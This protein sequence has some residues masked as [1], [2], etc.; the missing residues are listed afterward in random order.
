MAV[1]AGYQDSFFVCFLT[2]LPI[3]LC[4]YLQIC[5]RKCPLSCKK[6]IQLIE[7]NLSQAHFQ[8]KKTKGNR[9]GNHPH[10]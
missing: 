9:N 1:Q 4:Y 10:C 7:T 8:V 5:C 3:K 6:L 2:Y